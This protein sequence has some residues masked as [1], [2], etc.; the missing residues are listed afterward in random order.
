MLSSPPYT[1]VPLPPATW[2]QQYGIG[3]PWLALLD[4][5]VLQVAVPEEPPWIPEVHTMHLL[6][7][8]EQ[9]LCCWRHC[10]FHNHAPCLTCLQG[11]L[12]VP[13]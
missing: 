5:D 2:C 9:L 6:L 10:N 13:S 4:A 7:C 8:L 1:I 11:Q 3:T 12:G